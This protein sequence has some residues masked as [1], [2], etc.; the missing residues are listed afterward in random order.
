MVH[1]GEGVQKG[2]RGEMDRDV[3]RMFREGF[4][5]GPAGTTIAVP[6]DASRG[7]DGIARLRASLLLCSRRSGVSPYAKADAKKKHAFSPFLGILGCV[8]D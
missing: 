4:R 5:G 1:R 7:C 8:F 2:F 6:L 3:K